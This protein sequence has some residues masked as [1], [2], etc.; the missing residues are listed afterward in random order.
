MFV[1]SVFNTR[2][3]KAITIIRIPPA[4][5]TP[6]I[7]GGQGGLCVR[8]FPLP[9]SLNVS[10]MARRHASGRKLTEIFLPVAGWGN[11]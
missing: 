8:R 10:P 2:K 7:K 11:E 5:A 6:L 4:G 1:N 3:I 9:Y